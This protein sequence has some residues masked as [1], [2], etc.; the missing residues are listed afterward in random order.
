MELFI[1]QINHFGG[2]QK[3]LIKECQIG[4]KE[5]WRERASAR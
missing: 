5:R 2:E 3:S 4:N 1:V